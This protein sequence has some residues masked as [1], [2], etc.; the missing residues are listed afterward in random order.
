MKQTNHIVSIIL[1]VHNAGRFLRVSIESVLKQT[2]NNI[3]VIAIDDDSKDDSYRILKRF[4]REDK[5]FKAYRN[6]KRYGLAICLNRAVKRAKGQFIGFMDPTHVSARSRIKKQLNFLLK[7]PKVVAVGLQCKIIDHKNRHLGKTD[8]PT[9]HD[10]IYKMLPRGSSFAFETT[11]IN[12]QLLPKD[13][14]K[15]TSSAYPFVYTQVFMQF[16][17]YGLLANLVDYLHS[18]R[19][20]TIKT[21]KEL[22]KVDHWLSYIKLWLTSIAQ[23]QYRPSLRSFF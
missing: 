2:Y 3:E 18:Y 11:L 17:Q 1:P 14:L 6:K 16:M 13:L 9:T 12:K 15:F 22:R 21:Y 10:D 8:F 23:Y 5:R 19:K 20:T 7:H 4:S